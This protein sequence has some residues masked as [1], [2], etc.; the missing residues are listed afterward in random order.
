MRGDGEVEVNV[1]EDW[2]RMTAPS[3]DLQLLNFLGGW[4]SLDAA[5]GGPPEGQRKVMT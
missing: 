3:L 1:A 5:T 2:R 4:S